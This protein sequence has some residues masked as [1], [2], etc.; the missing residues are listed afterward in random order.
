MEKLFESIKRWKRLAD[1]AE[2]IYGRIKDKDGRPALVV[3][4]LLY[5]HM[6]QEKIGDQRLLS[7]LGQYLTTQYPEL[8]EYFVSERHRKEIMEFRRTLDTILEEKHG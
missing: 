2:R 3:L 5:R 7:F 1:D 6:E 4:P 8:S